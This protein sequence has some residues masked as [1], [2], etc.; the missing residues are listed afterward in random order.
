[1][2]PPP[3]SGKAGRLSNPSKGSTKLGEKR[4]GL[5]LSERPERFLA[6]A[7]TKLQREQSSG[8]SK[9]PCRTN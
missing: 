6:A 7:K 1:M 8:A 9:T 3:L 2:A 4:M 5:W